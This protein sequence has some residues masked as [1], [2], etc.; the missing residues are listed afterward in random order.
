MKEEEMNQVFANV[1]RRID[2]Q[3]ELIIVENDILN[4]L[5]KSGAGREFMKI[6]WNKLYR[7]AGVDEKQERR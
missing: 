2:L 6:D 1:R 5:I 3:G 4:S 7:A